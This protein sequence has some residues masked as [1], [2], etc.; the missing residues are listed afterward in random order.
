MKRICLILL[1]LFL[2]TSFAFAVNSQ[3]GYSTKNGK[4]AVISFN[5]TNTNGDN[6]LE[7]IGLTNKSVVVKLVAGTVAYDIVFSNNNKQ[8]YAQI[9]SDKTT[10]QSF[11]FY[12]EATHVCVTVTSCAACNVTASIQAGD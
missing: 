1:T 10:S 4:L 5:A 11:E 3:T 8:T 7:V 9:W 2:W 12:T 6:C